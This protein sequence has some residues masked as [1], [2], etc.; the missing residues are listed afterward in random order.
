LLSFIAQG[1]DK[2]LIPAHARPAFRL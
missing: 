1:S 2:P